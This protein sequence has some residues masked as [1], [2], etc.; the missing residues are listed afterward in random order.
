M[1]FF[2]G[3]FPNYKTM[4]F[5]FGGLQNGE[6]R[7]EIRAIVAEKTIKFLPKGKLSQFPI[8]KV[9]NLSLLILDQSVK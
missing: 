7:Y 4:G 8:Q 6:I 9:P 1:G 5:Y 3:T 2:L